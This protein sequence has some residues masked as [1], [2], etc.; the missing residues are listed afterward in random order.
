[1]PS[2]LVNRGTLRAITM[3]KFS[4]QH[5]LIAPSLLIRSVVLGSTQADRYYG[6]LLHPTGGIN[7]VDGHSTLAAG[8]RPGL[9][10]LETLNT[11][12]TPGVLRLRPAIKG[13][14]TLEARITETSSR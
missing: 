3:T 8:E 4:D 7:A 13:R 1:M 14:S 6:K 9:L 12:R 5:R 10:A 11:R 2:K